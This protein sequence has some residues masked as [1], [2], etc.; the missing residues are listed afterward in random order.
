V[1]SYLNSATGDVDN[2]GDLDVW[3]SA[4]YGETA[5]LYVSN[6]GLSTG[7]F[8]V[9]DATGAYGLSGIGVTTQGAFGDMDNDG[10]LDFVTNNGNVFSYNKM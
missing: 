6:L 9:S 8:S 4:V 3:L 1:E 5:R 2:D 7:A 10:D